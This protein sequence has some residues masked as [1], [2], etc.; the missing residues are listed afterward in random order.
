[1][2]NEDKTSGVILALVLIAV[3]VGYGL[4]RAFGWL[5]VLAVVPVILI[6]LGY[7]LYSRRGR[8]ASRPPRR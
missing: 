1:V 8:D 5:P 6:L 7:Y 4:Q 3:G 2:E